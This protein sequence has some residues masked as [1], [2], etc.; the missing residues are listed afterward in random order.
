MRNLMKLMAVVAVVAMMAG[1]A[2]AATI[3]ASKDSRYGKPLPSASRGLLDCSSV[4]ELSAGY[5]NPFAYLPA[6]GLVD[7]WLGYG[8]YW[9]GG[10]VVFHITFPASTYGWNWQFGFVPAAG[11]DPDLFIMDG[12]CGEEFAAYF[13]D[14]GVSATGWTGAELWFCLDGYAA[15]TCYM[16]VNFDMQEYVPFDFCA[17]VIDV[18]GVG[19]FVGDTC[20]GYNTPA[21]SC[22]II[23]PTPTQYLSDGQEDYYGVFMPAGSSFLA[24]VDHSCDASLR[25]MDACLEPVNCVGYVDAVYPDTFEDMPFTNDTGVDALFYLVIDAYDDCCGVYEMDFSSTDGAIANEA[26]T[27]GEVKALW[28]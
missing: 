24:H 9:T 12:G 7:D 2:T 14:G 28:R 13:F 27:L 11:C 26:M 22:V 1:I 21:G 5:S 18:T 8:P 6:T 10:E 15:S 17:D 23:P 4:T 19:I 20:D 16:E 25:V 3:H